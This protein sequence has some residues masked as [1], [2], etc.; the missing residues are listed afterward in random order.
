MLRVQGRPRQGRVGDDQ[1]VHARVDRGAGDRVDLPRLQVGRDLEEK[2]RQRRPAFERRAHLVPGLPDRRD[3]RAQRPFVL[4]PP[5]ARSVGR[6]DVDGEIDA[7][8]AHPPDALDI[9]GDPVLA[10]LIGPD[11]DPHPARIAPRHLVF[12][13]PERRPFRRPPNVGGVESLVVEAHPVDHRPVLRQPEQ[14]RLRISRLRPRS[15]RSDLD[16]AEAEAEHLAIDL[17]VLVEARGEADRVRKVDPGDLD[18]QHR[19]GRRRKSG[20]NRLQR[21][22]RQPMRP[23]RVER[24]DQ[25]SDEGIKRHPPSLRGA[26]RRSNPEPPGHHDCFDPTRN[27]GLIPGATFAKC[28]S[29]R[30]G[31]I[32]TCASP[33]LP[34][35]P[36]W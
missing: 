35:M 7:V 14:P 9:I 33:P 22:D 16:E 24:E 13:P 15:Q 5:Q 32:R 25:R 12:C 18:R 6:G 20:R 4:K 19:I 36:S 34:I 31:P 26:E 2:R 8:A 21:P 11:V 27:D 17:A 29:E 30:I 28:Q 10:V 3:Q 1:P 23:L